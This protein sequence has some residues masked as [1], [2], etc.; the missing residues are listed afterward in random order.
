MDFSRFFIDRP[1][2]A[3]VLSILIFVAGV[4][5]I[6]LLP[7]SEYPD[8]V[9]PSVQVR[10]EY[11]GAN[12][13]EIAETVAT[14]LEEAINGVENM[15][16]M[17][18]VAGSDGVLV[19]TVT[20]RPGTDPDQAQVQVQNRVAQAE[21]RLPE[22]VRRQGITT[23]KQS[24]ALTLVVHL[25]SPSGKY[26]SLYLR[27][28]A[29]L[30]VKDEL[31]RLPGVGQVQI[32]GAGE[33]AMRIWLDPNKVA[34]R[35]L[36]ASDVVSA[37]QEQ[38]VQ[39][40][41][42]QL[43]AEP[44]PTRSDYLLS[45]NAQG[46]LQTEE[47]FGNII[48]KSG[49]NGEI[50]RLR[51][52]A[53]IEMGSGSYALRAQLNNKD[54]VGIGIFQSP[55]ANAIELSDAVRGKMA[56]LATR[57]PDGMSWKS[58]YDPTVFVRDSIRAVVD[59]LL[60]AVILVVLVVIL[61]LQTWRASIIP[62]LAVP[63]SVVGTFAALYL[64]GFSLNTL[65]LFGLVLAIGIVVDDAIVVVENVERNIEEGLSPLAAAHP[66][67]RE[68]SGPII[69]IA[70]VLC[71]VF[72]PMAF[73]SGV[74]GQFYKQF[75]VTIAISTVISAINSLT[76]SPALAARLLKPHGAPKDLPSRLI[77]R[78]FGWLFRPFNRFFASGS[79]RYQ[80]GVSRVLGRRGAVFVV[81][82]LLLVAA[83][84]MF[85]T[86]P[87]GFIPTQ[88]KLYLIGG[89]KMPEGASLERTDAVIRK[90]SAIGLSVDGVT[91]AVAFPGLNALQFTNTPNTGTVFFALE[92]LSTRTRTAAQINAEIN[93][94]ISQIQE[95]FA[96]SIMPP[97][98][99]GIGQGSG[100]SLYVQDRG[101]LGYGAL[102]TA[103]NTMSG[104]I[105]QTPGM[106]FPI[107]SYQANVPQLDAKI[108]RDKAKAQGVPL[109]ALFS[110]LQTYLGSSYINDFNRYGRTWKVMAQADGQFRDSVEDIAN[111]RTRNDKGEM[112]PIGSMVSIGTTYGPDPV[113][114]YNGF[115]AAD[116][117]GDADPRVLSSTQAMSALTQMAG[118]LLPNGMNIQWTDLSYQQSTQGNAALVVFPV[119][120]LLAFLALAALYE[121]WTLPLAVILIVP[122]TM[123]SAL[124]GVWLTGGDNNVFVQVGLVVLM[125]LA[126]K[127]AILIVEFA[128]EL[129]MQ[130]K[131]IVE[132]ALEA[133]RLRLRPIV[134][135]SIAFIAGT[136]PLILGHGAGAEVRGVT[137]ITV[138]SGMLGVTLFGLF[139]TPVFYVTLRRLV[140]RKTQTQTA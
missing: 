85:K 30:K 21:A 61:F 64:L 132:A 33:Y 51:D 44:M 107:S 117:I 137:G 52:V 29:T 114:R 124:F 8:V 22:D 24:P 7:I 36:T 140:A 72:V 130:G 11:P 78:L 57:F 90:M 126:C 5:A 74:T 91:D 108:D 63:I 100:Y 81:Y 82:L 94:R 122:M 101:G 3:A 62:L 109:N 35:G 135:T 69:A 2:F 19:T 92:S 98:I 34:A 27:N 16:Y 47:E 6:P 110:T 45:I 31:A 96:F 60:E 93:A 25:V 50:V 79:Q 43:G 83:G 12:P 99:L 112:V 55:G 54:A 119:A 116:L 46:R 128:R 95:G 23:Q 71:A 39:V 14:P 105:M 32:F 37:M 131:G 70:V 134:M 38:N 86:V 103:I 28:Y 80:H 10:A 73:L 118:K 106:G 133:C 75:A 9:P 42:G 4:I 1:I 138:F 88:D 77:D 120:V 111:L 53:R 48:L 89:V 115:P 136:I 18:S 123:L 127:N 102:Q 49:D 113:I 125:G 20:F 84:G 67:M 56:E 121:S 58:P 59:T 104:A 76:L 41:A 66:A 17:K 139:L 68:V 129:E 87:G 15:M 13:K 65:S 40:S 26:D 97:P